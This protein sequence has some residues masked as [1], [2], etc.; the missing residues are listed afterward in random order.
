MKTS[1]LVYGTY[2]LHEWERIT[3]IF[4]ENSVAFEEGLHTHAFR[5]EDGTYDFWY[6]HFLR[7]HVTKEEEQIIRAKRAQLKKIFG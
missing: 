6:F 1:L 3:R 4:E 7:A 2:N 5:L